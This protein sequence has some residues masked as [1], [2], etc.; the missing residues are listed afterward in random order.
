MALK[1]CA[2]FRT[3]SFIADNKTKIN[4]LTDDGGLPRSTLTTGA[5]VHKSTTASRTIGAKVA[6]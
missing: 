4:A 1:I 6:H 3:L 5:N 2:R